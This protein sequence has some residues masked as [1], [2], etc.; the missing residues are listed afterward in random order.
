MTRDTF[1]DGDDTPFKHEE[2]K[3]K[4][5][6]IERLFGQTKAVEKVAPNSVL[7]YRVKFWPT[8]RFPYSAI[9]TESNRSLRESINPALPQSFMDLDAAHR[10]AKRE[11]ETVRALR[12]KRDE[13]NRLGLGNPRD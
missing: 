11:I 2:P 13:F 4:M 3:R 12:A 5:N 1:F 7:T 9:I 8:E 6:W 10:W